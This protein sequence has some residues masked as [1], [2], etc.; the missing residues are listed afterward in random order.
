M[1]SANYD[2][3]PSLPQVPFQHYWRR[4]RPAMKCCV[5]HKLQAA[6]EMEHL[7][8]AQT[9]AQHNAT[10]IAVLGAA[11]ERMS[12]TISFYIQNMTARV[13]RSTHWTELPVA[14]ALVDRLLDL[15]R[16][17]AC[18]IAQ[19]SLC[20]CCCC[21]LGFIADRT[22]NSMA[23]SLRSTRATTDDGRLF[24]RDWMNDDRSADLP[25]TRWNWAKVTWLLIKLLFFDGLLSSSFAGGG[26]LTG[27]V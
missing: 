15:L 11:S 19:Y 3:A 13:S 2:R 23:L 26:E 20:L 21:W 12:A 1:A 5:G 17:I 9:R 8:G 6:P 14:T 16:P 7:N 18:T 22:L 4:P 27:Y 10:I 25:G 24:T